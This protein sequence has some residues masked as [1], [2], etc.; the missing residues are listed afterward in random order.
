MLGTSFEFVE[1]EKANIFK[2]SGEIYFITFVAKDRN[3]TKIFQA[4]VRNVFCRE[5]EH[6]FCRLKPGQEGT[7]QLELGE[8]MKASFQF[9]DLL[10]C[11][12]EEACVM[13]Q[14]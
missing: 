11:S 5:I 2:F 12:G 14:Y 9:V 13:V 4:K 7:F 10:Y 1:V 8:I 3:Q 6:C